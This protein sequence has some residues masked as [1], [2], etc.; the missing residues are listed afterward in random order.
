[1]ERSS[2]SLNPPSSRNDDKIEIADIFRGYSGRLGRISAQQ[3][4]VINAIINCRTKNLGGH[5]LKCNKCGNKESSYN[6]CR[7]RH[8][9]K[10]QSL[11]GVK[12]VEARKSDLLPVQ[13]FHIVFTFSDALYPVALFNK[14]VVYNVLFKAVSETIK[15]CAANKK[16]LG[17]YAGC[18]AVLHTWDQQLNHHPHIHCIAP[19]GG[20]S[21]DKKKWISSSRDFFI[22]VGILSTVFRGKFLEYLERAFHAEELKFSGKIS[23]LSDYNSF[24]NLLRKSCEKNWVVYSKKPFAGPEQVLNYLGRYTH[25]VAVSNYRIL[26]LDNDVVTFKW[27]DRRNGNVEKI[28]KLDVVL[29]MKRFLLHVLPGSFVRIR[30]YGFLG[31]RCK[32]KLIALC[33]KLLGVFIA[34]GDENPA[35]IS[36]QEHVIELTGSDPALC[37]ACGRGRMVFYRAIKPA[38]LFAWGC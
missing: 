22:Y 26:S 31:N 7:N 12:W 16:N 8:C 9:P 33:R 5:T 14:K 35:R 4:K 37:P 32:K 34:A 27:R 24:K 36:W 19:G 28:M 10:C 20:L 25:R 2:D 18:I 38:V 13:Y 29:F 17:A 1:M 23:H 6:S 15:E 3:N 30:H 21:F 11:S